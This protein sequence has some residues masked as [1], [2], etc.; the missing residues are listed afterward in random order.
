[1]GTTAQHG[2]VLQGGPDGGFSYQSCLPSTEGQREEE[3]LESHRLQ[4][5]GGLKPACASRACPKA[6]GRAG[7]VRCPPGAWKGGHE[8]LL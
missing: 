5:A 2:A 8:R 7:K 4:E 3:S 1:M 6:L